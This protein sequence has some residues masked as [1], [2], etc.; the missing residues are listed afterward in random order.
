MDY[1]NPGVTVIEP[2]ARLTVYV[3][4]RDETSSPSPGSSTARD[5]PA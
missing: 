1:S 5:A 4:S 3:Q 2:E